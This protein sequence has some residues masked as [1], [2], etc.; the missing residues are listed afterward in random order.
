MLC[1]HSFN[2]AQVTSS[3]LELPRVGEEFVQVVPQ[4]VMEAVSNPREICG[5]FTVAVSTKGFSTLGV[6]WESIESSRPM[7]LEIQHGPLQRFNEVHKSSRV[8]TYDVFD[9]SWLNPKSGFAAK[10]DVW[11]AT[12]SIVFDRQ[13]SQKGSSDSDKGG[14]DG[15]EAGLLERF[16]GSHGQW[17]RS[18]WSNSWM[19][20]PTHQSCCRCWRS[21]HWVEWQ[22]LHRFWICKAAWETEPG[23]DPHGLAVSIHPRWHAHLGR[24]E[25]PVSVFCLNLHFSRALPNQ[26]VFP[27]SWAEFHGISST[28]QAAWA[29]ELETWTIVPAM[30]ATS[31]H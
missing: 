2:E 9:C 5:T 19:E 31:F 25:P 27:L 6:Q 18:L 23:E 17:P 20:C 3:E 15:D 22:V 1:C 10:E 14:C 11:W 29:V 7:I 13:S 26:G 24:L 4:P 30:M 28:S 12:R 8:E 21:H 16:I